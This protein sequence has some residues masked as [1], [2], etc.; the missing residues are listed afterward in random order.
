LDRRGAGGVGPIA[1]SPRPC[2]SDGQRGLTQVNKALDLQATKADDP[3]R[4]R[5]AP[6]CLSPTL[7]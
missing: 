1:A 6:A 2:A 5:G 4:S 3:A 7:I